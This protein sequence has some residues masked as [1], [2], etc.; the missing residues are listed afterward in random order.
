MLKGKKVRAWIIEWFVDDIIQNPSEFKGKRVLEVGSKY[1][2]GSVRPFIEKL[3]YPQEYIGIDIEEGKYVDM[4]LSAEKLVDCFGEES[5]DIVI[6]TE[7]L[8]HVWGWRVVIQNMK[9]VLKE[10]GLIF[11]T[12]CSYG[13]NYHGYPHDFWRYEPKDMERIF[14][15]FSVLSVG[16]EGTT[17]FL[18]ACK[19][20]NYIKNNLSDISIYSIAIGKRT[21]SDGQKLSFKRKILL[22]LRKHGLID[23]VV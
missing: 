20:E 5:F 19:P 1:V 7:L 17:T 15:D 21:K 23:K 13:F 11:I 10:K 18:K 9:G 14:S 8:E 22:G 6:S 4:V 3:G 16:K 12:T 2:N